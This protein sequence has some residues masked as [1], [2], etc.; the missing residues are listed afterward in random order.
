MGHSMGGQISQ[1]VAIR[2]PDRVKALVLE[3]VEGPTLA[4]RL[5]LGPI[6]FDDVLPMAERRPKPSISV[7]GT[8]SSS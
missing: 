7:L 8:M 3:L 2:A 6:P 5:A 1:E 4:D